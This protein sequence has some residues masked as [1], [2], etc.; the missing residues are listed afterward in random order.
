M[1]E[2]PFILLYKG[3]SGKFDFILVHFLKSIRSKIHISLSFMGLM[4]SLTTQ[5]WPGNFGK[6]GKMQL[7]LRKIS[8]KIF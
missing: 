5:N 4:E 2:V 8:Q 7:K 1:V 6:I 3:H